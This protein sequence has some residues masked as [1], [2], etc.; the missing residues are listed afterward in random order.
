[1]YLGP[2]VCNLVISPFSSLRVAEPQSPCPPISL[3]LS[4][5][6]SLPSLPT[7]Q[8]IL[9]LPVNS[10]TD[11]SNRLT[12][13]PARKCQR[14]KEI[15]QH[16]RIA[17]SHQLQKRSLSKTSSPIHPPTPSIHPTTT[18]KTMNPRHQ[19]VT[20]I[21]MTPNPERSQKSWRKLWVKP[22]DN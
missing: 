2:V 10:I 17:Q 1:M 3:H 13:S 6:L 19:L 5:S 16:D 22:W 9:S 11:S 12:D 7:C 8:L 20:R 15:P 14:K 21:S 4:L 18:P